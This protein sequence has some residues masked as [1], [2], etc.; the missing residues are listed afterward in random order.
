[1]I[2]IAVLRSNTRMWY[3][4]NVRETEGAIK[5]GQSRETDNTWYTWHRTETNKTKEKTSKTL[6]IS[7]TTHLGWSLV[8]LIRH[9]PCYSYSQYVLDT[10]RYTITNTNNVNKTWA[11]LQ[12]TGGK[13][14]SQYRKQFLIIWVLP[15]LKRFLSYLTNNVKGHGSSSSKDLI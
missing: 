6:K 2:W 10:T 13:V 7:N 3:W 11:L 5:N 12:T 9:P 14:A 15:Y 4:I 8:P 1:M